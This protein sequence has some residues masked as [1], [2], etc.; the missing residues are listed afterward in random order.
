MYTSAME[1]GIRELRA[2]AADAVSR[3]H[4][5]ERIIITVNGRP[6]AQLGPIAPLDSAPS[7][8]D[9]AAQGLVVLPHRPDRPPSPL[10]IDLWTGV[11]L[12]RLIGEV[13]GR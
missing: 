9:L 3:A 7:L 2:N 5:G 12:D 6:T 1:I 11:R 8:A 10:A 13:R 4:N